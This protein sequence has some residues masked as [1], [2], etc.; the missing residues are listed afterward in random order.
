[1]R[2]QAE[3]IQDLKSTMM[4]NIQLVPDL[5]TSKL[6]DLD[7]VGWSE[8]CGGKRPPFHLFENMKYTYTFKSKHLDEINK[9]NKKYNCHSK[10]AVFFDRMSNMW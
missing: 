1:M 6:R 7:K 9:I 2:L 3:K 4:K 8:P 5:V 10:M